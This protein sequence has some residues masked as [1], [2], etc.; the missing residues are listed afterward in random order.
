MCEEK[1]PFPPLSVFIYFF[2]NILNEYICVYPTYMI[3]EV[4]ILKKINSII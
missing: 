1:T 4:K 3:I 2:S